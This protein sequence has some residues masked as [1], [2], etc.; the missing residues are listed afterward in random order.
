MSVELMEKTNNNENV[1]R[2]ASSGAIG[3]YALKALMSEQQQTLKLRGDSFVRDLRQPLAVFTGDTTLSYK[4]SEAADT[5]YIML[6]TGEVNVPSCWFNG[7]YSDGELRFAAHHEMGHFIDLRSNPEA[8]LATFEE[9]R[10]T[11]NRLAKDYL[12]THQCN[13]NQAAVSKFF[14]KELD[15]FN[16]VLDDIY[17][18]N[19]VKQRAPL[20]S[21]AERKK[22]I[23]SLYKK[24]GYG[25]EN[26]AKCYDKDGNEYGEQPLHRQMLIALLREEMLAENKGSFEETEMSPEVREALNKK[27]YGMTIYETIK[28][29]IVPKYNI[30]VDPEKRYE[31]IRQRI[32]PLYIDLLK[33]ELDK[34]REPEPPKEQPKEPPTESPEGDENEGGDSDNFDP[35]NDKENKEKKPHNI[36]SK[37]NEKQKKQINEI[38][39]KQKYDNMSPEERGENDKAKMQELF[40]KQHNIEQG[41]RR[42]YE[43]IKKVIKEARRKMQRFWN[44]LIGKS[45]S[46]EKK[47]TPEQ[48]KGKDDIKSLIKHYAE[49]VGGMRSGDISNVPMRGRNEF[50]KQVINKPERIDIS[51]LIDASGSMDGERNKMAKA[52]ATLL[53]LSVKD[54]NKQLDIDRKKT[55]SKLRARTEVYTFNSECN[56][57][58]RFEGVGEKIDENE[59]QIVRMTSRIGADGGTNEVP[60]YEKIFNSLT[61]AD[62][63]GIQEGKIKK[64]VFEITDGVPDDMYA[65][66]RSV[67]KLRQCGVELYGFQIDEEENEIFDEIWNQDEKHQYGIHVGNDVTKLPEK[68]IS[69]AGAL[70]KDIRI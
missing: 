8:L 35:F 43:A 70:L 69:V 30:L 27:M 15:D 62:K 32:R 51:L 36:L 3:G 68:L 24:V 42:E 1:D 19:I 6:K 52:A 17:V 29:K 2:R 58:K 41:E 49:Y 7:E 61:E 28:N 48:M 25:N 31:I 45:I 34:I 64:I 47:Y 57:I 5:F 37:D 21:N 22:D 67:E 23:E 14:E 53:A 13:A 55:K 20:F 65:V 39:E 46:Y 4:V 26:I 50:E 38:I 59:A 10:K 66:K 18:N 56:I 9:S 12:S 11:A 60:A 44:S 16:N 54:F 33:K 63:K 40:D